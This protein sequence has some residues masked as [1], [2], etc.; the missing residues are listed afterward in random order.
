MGFH[1]FRHFFVTKAKEAG[2]P[3][4]VI[5]EI[6]GWGSPEMERT[7]NHI[8]DKTLTDAVK[9]LEP[10][11]AVKEPSSTAPSVD[12]QSLANI[13]DDELSRTC[14]AILDVIERRR[15]AS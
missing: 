14:K 2:I 9:K 3:S 10:K 12:G 4:D 11:P 13:A 5:Q 7:Y 1:S 15:Q 8:S 6:V